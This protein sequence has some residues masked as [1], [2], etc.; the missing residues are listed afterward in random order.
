MLQYVRG[1]RIS[2]LSSGIEEKVPPQNTV[3]S[4]VPPLLKKPAI[5]RKNKGVNEMV[6]VPESPKNRSSQWKERTCPGVKR[7]TGW[8]IM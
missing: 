1:D 5:H 7:M 8:W 6:L 3:S 4:R 2:V